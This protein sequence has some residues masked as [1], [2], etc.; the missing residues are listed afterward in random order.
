M[1]WHDFLAAVALHG[2]LQVAVGEWRSVQ[3]R[4]LAGLDIAR[5]GESVRIVV[6]AK[7]YPYRYVLVARPGL[8]VRCA[9]SD[10]WEQISAKIDQ[11]LSNAARLGES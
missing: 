4:R 5:R 2:T 7:W 8:T 6:A 3:P 10:V 1:R 11:S 9:L